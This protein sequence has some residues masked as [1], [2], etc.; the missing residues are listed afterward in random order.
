MALGEV[1]D[2]MLSD[3]SP[4]KIMYEV[5]LTALTGMMATAP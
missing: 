1:I 3:H 4:T 2:V 5:G